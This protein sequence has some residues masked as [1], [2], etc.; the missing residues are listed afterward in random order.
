MKDSVSALFTNDS[1]V[2][3]SAF[4]NDLFS[5]LGIFRL[6]EAVPLAPLAMYKFNADVVAIAQ[7][8]TKINNIVLISLGFFFMVQEH[9]SLRQQDVIGSAF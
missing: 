6:F 9:K 2:P 3:L 4:L 1:K 5:F 8:I 7:A